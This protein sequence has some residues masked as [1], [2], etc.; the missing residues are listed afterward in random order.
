[1]FDPHR[2]CADVFASSLMNKLRTERGNQVNRQT[3]QNQKQEK[4][5]TM[6]LPRVSERNPQATITLTQHQAT[7]TWAAAATHDTITTAWNTSKKKKASLFVGKSSMRISS[8]RMYQS[9]RERTDR[10][11]FLG[12]PRGSG[13]A[14]SRMSRSFTKRLRGR[15][16]RRRMQS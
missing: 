9:P 6:L 5:P 13:R 1:M 16:R 11:G 12:C 7:A 3:T 4:D 2:L 15:C 14:R 10:R 8:C